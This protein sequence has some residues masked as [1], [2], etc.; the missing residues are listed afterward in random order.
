[1]SAGT[2]I[3]GSGNFY[4]TSTAS[5]STPRKVVTMQDISFDLSYATK[6]L[7]GQNSF[8]VDVRRGEAKFGGKAKFANVNGA[9]L[10]DLFYNQTAT[11]GQLLASVSEAGSIPASVSYI[12]T[13]ANSATF[14]TDLGV[15]YATT[16]IPFT[17]VASAPTVGQYSVAAGVYTFAA[18]DASTAVYIDYLYTSATGGTKIAL[19][20]QA[21]GLT[22]FF[23]GVFTSNV[24]GKIV[25]LKLNQCTSSKLSFSTKIEDYGIHELDIEIM[26]DAGN[27]I[28]TLSISN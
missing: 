5:N 22:P 1:M 11:I 23:T 14:D 28:G 16:G 4:G 2:L 27:N 3:F 8:P 24:S 25:T 19:S 6:Q 7:F 20:N 18:A 15:I 13:V 12:V 9:A 26:A 21:M 17:K 10:N